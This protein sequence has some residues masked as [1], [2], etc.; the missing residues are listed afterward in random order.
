MCRKGDLES[1]LIWDVNLL[2]EQYNKIRMDT[3][4]TFNLCTKF[5]EILVHFKALISLLK[6]R[7]VSE[8]AGV[9]VGTS[10]NL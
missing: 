10:L 2:R 3:Y 7:K 8:R 5:G 6:P 1:R 9:C 4:L